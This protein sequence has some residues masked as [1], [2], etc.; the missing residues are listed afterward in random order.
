MKLQDIHETKS[1]RL[2]AA[3]RKSIGRSWGAIPNKVKTQTTK[4]SL[5]TS[6]GGKDTDRGEQAGARNAGFT[7]LASGIPHKPR[8]R[9]FFGVKIPDGRP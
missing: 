1:K 9:E 7:S 5:H 4:P 3:L 8:H 6:T 2:I